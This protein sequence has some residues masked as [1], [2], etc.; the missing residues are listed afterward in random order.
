M[1]GAAPKYASA[2][3]TMMTSPGIFN[4]NSVL[5]CP[6]GHRL[7]RPIPDPATEPC[8]PY[9]A[10]LGGP[11]NRRAPP[12]NSESGGCRKVPSRGRRARSPGN[13]RIPGEGE[14]A[15]FS[16]GVCLP[17]FLF[18]SPFSVFHLYGWCF[19]PRMEH[20]HPPRV[21]H[22]FLPVSFLAQL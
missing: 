16:K 19:L 14:I 17:G 22:V 9:T 5:I 15:M 13:E 7:S 10:A 6:A 2:V 21:F 12:S 11:G 18:L 3:V 4:T 20:C 8:P 1:A